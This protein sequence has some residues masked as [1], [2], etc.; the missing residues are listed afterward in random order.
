MWQRM[1]GTA[2][3]VNHVPPEGKLTLCNRAEGKHNR[4]HQ[5]RQRHRGT[6]LDGHGVSG[7]ESA[8]GAGG[9]QGGFHRGRCQRGPVE[10]ALRLAHARHRHQ[11]CM[12]QGSPSSAAQRTRVTDLMR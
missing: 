10:S 9:E 2:R 3:C 4:Q 1:M 11:A 6:G 5:Q 7:A 8:A 12:M